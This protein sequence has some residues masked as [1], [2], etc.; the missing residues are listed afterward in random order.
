MEHRVIS[1]DD[2]LRITQ[3][4][5]GV[6][7]FKDAM[8]QSR[9]SG[10]LARAID[11][12]EIWFNSLLAGGAIAILF[13]GGVGI[14]ATIAIYM[15]LTNPAVE[16]AVFQL[17]TIKEK[18]NNG[19][20]VGA[21]AKAAKTPK[22]KPNQLVSREKKKNQKR[23]KQPPESKVNKEEEESDRQKLAAMDKEFERLLRKIEARRSLPTKRIDDD[24]MLE[25][26]GVACA[27]AREDTDWTTEE[28]AD[29]LSINR[30]TVWRME[31]GQMKM[32]LSMLNSYCSVIGADPETVA[33]RAYS[34]HVESLM[35]SLMEKVKVGRK[36]S[37]LTKIVLMLKSVEKKL[38]HS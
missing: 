17:L 8:P 26:G 13:L 7:R 30:T 5:A 9:F 4:P 25:F 6:D 29:A 24:P 19:A 18:R 32:K 35:E 28:V 12:W 36:A 38:L 22:T 37:F 3:D 2:Y 21:K 11:D 1:A 34:M 10:W 27:E 33:A 14:A 31:T 23:E 16:R 15:L 20:K